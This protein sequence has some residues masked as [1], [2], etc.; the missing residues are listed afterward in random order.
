MLSITNAHSI[1][2]AAL[3][4]LVSEIFR[5]SDGFVAN[6]QEKYPSLEVFSSHCNSLRNQEAGLFLVA[7][8]FNQPCGF[9]IIDQR[10]LEKI[11]HGADLSMGV[12]ADH[13]GQGVGRALLQTTISQVRAMGRLK[14]ID[15]MVRADNIAAVNLY[16]AAGFSLVG[17]LPGDLFSDGKYYDGHLM[18]LSL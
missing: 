1:P 2:P 10:R 6:L 3:Y 9:I 16:R 7:T 13:R 14:K 8:Q 5:Q 18:S 12:L 11:R 17:T 15:L 4:H